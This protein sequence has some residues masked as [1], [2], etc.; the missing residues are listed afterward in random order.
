MEPAL[1]LVEMEEF[2]FMIYKLVHFLHRQSQTKL[3]FILYLNIWE[4]PCQFLLIPGDV[5][6]E[7]TRKTTEDTN[8]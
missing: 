2:K 6:R 3:W 4:S 7:R 8:W 1:L 5:R